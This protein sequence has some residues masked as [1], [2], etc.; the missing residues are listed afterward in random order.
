MSILSDKNKNTKV[1]LSATCTLFF[2]PECSVA[3]FV[4]AL[5]VNA[6]KY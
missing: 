1:F 3:S 4:K 6:H 5:I 2:S